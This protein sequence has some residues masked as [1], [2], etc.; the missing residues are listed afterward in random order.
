MSELEL[1]EGVNVIVTDEAGDPSV[2]TVESS[3]GR[4]RYNVVNNVREDP[5]GGDVFHEWTCTCPAY[6]YGNGKACKHM[7]LV[8]VAA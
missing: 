6:E 3:D 2:Y 1:P 8:G 5:D 7:K 4:R